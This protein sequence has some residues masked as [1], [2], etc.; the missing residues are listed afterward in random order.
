MT[1]GKKLQ[2]EILGL[3]KEEVKDLWEEEDERFLKQLSADLAREKVLS[4][5][6]DKPAEHE[7]NLLH[8]AATLQ[9]E[10]ARK[11]LK[12]NKKGKDLFVRVLTLVVKTVA[13]SALGIA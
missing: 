11:R 5:T 7:R 4:L 6:S 1:D 2:E 3:L 9:G 8:L 13:L 12:L 10:V